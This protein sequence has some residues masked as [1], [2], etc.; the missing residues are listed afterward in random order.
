M[1]F[2]LP[3]VLALVIAA[4][5]WAAGGPTTPHQR[6]KWTDG[7]GN[8]HYS[9]ALP[10]E[11]VKYGYEVV[12]AQ[13]VVTKHVDRP[14]TAE[15]KAAAKAEI[16][17]AQA[18]KESADARARNDKQLLA[19]Y[20]TEDDLKRAQHQ[21][22]D[23]MDTNLTSA[24][25]SLQSQ[26]KS[27]AELLGHAADLDSNGKPIPANLAKKIADMRKQV[28]EQRTYITRK[29]K[30]RDDTVAHFDDDLAHYRS[31]KEPQEADRR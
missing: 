2:V 11:A 18:A 17:K 24:R 13:G 8:V 19:A 20:P 26:E 16:A 6:Y 9:D 28:E 7:E 22:A 10:P 31:L 25:I 29:Q 4:P 5:A 23:M 12:N 27:L 21:Q 15:E 3:A 14:K 30:E 1:R